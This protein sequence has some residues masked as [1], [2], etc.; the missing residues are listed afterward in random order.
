[1]QPDINA[2]LNAVLRKLGMANDDFVTRTT[3]CPNGCARPYMAEMALVGSGP[4][5]YQVWLGGHPAQ[6]ERTAQAV[7][8]LFKMKMDDLEKTFEPIFAMYKTQRVA[9]NEAFGNFCHRVGIPAIEEYMDKYE[10][11][12]YK[13]MV[14][15][16]AAPKITTDATVGIDSGLL[17]KLEEEAT[18][19]GYDTA[20][21]LDLLV[22]DA[23]DVEDG[24]EA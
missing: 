24:E 4:N 20:T 7:P 15:P 21:L 14:D 22:R 23:F 8:S 11:G 17:A 9:P 16:F 6:S 2:K 3:G 13:E 5:M 10:A 1:M 19:R 18:A 12:S